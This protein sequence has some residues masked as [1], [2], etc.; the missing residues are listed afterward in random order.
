MSEAP[1]YSLADLARSSEEVKAKLRS[2][3]EL[4]VD[5]GGKPIAKVIPFR[6]SCR[7]PG[8]GSLKTQVTLADDWDSDEVNEEIARLF[9]EGDIFPG[10]E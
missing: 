9:Y 1:H 8:R 3:D 2:G 10:N 4:I 7:R 5:E 6:R